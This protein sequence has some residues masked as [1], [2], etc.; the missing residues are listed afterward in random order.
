MRRRLHP[1][2]RCRGRWLVFVPLLLLHVQACA[3]AGTG[4]AADPRRPVS[5]GAPN[6]V[7]PEDF[8]YVHT[9]RGAPRRGRSG[10]RSAGQGALPG[11]HGRRGS[12]RGGQAGRGARRIPA[13][14]RRLAVAGGLDPAGGPGQGAAGQDRAG[15]GVRNGAP[16]REVPGGRR[17]RDGDA[18]RDRPRRERLHRLHEWLPARPRWARRN[19][20]YQ[21]GRGIGGYCRQLQAPG[22]RGRRDRER[23]EHLADS[24][25]APGCL[26][27]R[28]RRL[29]CRG[30]LR[31]L[32]RAMDFRDRRRRDWSR[33]RSR[34][35]PGRFDEFDLAYLVTRVPSRSVWAGSSKR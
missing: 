4:D 3:D 29:G 14:R 9:V 33:D 30:A 15:A 19:S 32:W 13:A 31:G 10:R 2:R 8:G 20:S 25:I 26:G 6:A 22:H 5:L 21:S 24:A 11:G 12:N 34:R 17:G 28:R 23:G 1:N 7:F 16:H 35:R 18:R 27:G